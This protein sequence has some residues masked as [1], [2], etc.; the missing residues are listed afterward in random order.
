MHILF[1]SFYAQGIFMKPRNPFTPEENIRVKEL[2]NEG[3][4]L[5]QIARAMNRDLNSVRGKVRELQKKG[6]IALREKWVRK[7]EGLDLPIEVTERAKELL[8]V[9]PEPV[10]AIQVEVQKPQ[11]AS[12]YGEEPDISM[13]VE[14]TAKAYG[15]DLEIAKTLASQLP[16]E[17]SAFFAGLPLVFQAYLEQKGYCYYLGTKAKLTA[18]T[19][20]VTGV[21]LMDIDTHQPVLVCRAVAN[22]RKG[23]S[24]KAFISMC[25]YIA[26]TF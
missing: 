23:L 13:A 20:E 3:Y 1:M 4:Q 6:E 11:E 10:K 21:V 19:S 24:H 16:Q 15:I 26:D 5:K 14:T 25:K 8:K 22:L 18:N 12:V 17:H 7:R 9:E 2:W